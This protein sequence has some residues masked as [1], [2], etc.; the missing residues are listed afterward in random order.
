MHLHLLHSQ[1]EDGADLLVIVDEVGCA[2]YGINDPG[3]FSGKITATRLTRPFLSDDS[4]RSR[5]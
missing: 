2:V 5:L 3:L 4:E 1:C